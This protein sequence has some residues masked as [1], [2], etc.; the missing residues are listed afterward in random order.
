MT[1]GMFFGDSLGEPVKTP[2]RKLAPEELFESYCQ[3]R[4]AIKKKQEKHNAR[5][6]ILEMKMNILRQF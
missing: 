6:K 2:K 4:E 1:H 5:L 3:E